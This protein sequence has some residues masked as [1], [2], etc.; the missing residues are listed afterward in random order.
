MPARVRWRSMAGYRRMPK[1]KITCRTSWPVTASIA[2]QLRRS[3]LLFACIGALCA[4]S[5]P[6]LPPLATMLAKH[7]DA[8]EAL[9][10]RE[11]QTHETTGT[12]L[13][14]GFS[15]TFHEWAQGDKS[16]RDDSFGI[17]TE[18]ILRL[19]D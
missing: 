15:G 6:P 10:V 18:R 17:R 1:P 2:E 7:L 16:R 4:Q 5:P 13:G 11:P 12:L 14:A 3:A 19:G 8:L 9:H